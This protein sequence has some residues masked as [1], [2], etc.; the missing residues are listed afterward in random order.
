MSRIFV[1]AGFSVFIFVLLE[2][3]TIEC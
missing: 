2:I 1:G 3:I